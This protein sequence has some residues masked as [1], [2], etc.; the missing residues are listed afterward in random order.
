MIIILIT[1][2]VIIYFFYFKKKNLETFK[3]STNL[4]NFEFSKKDSNKKQGVFLYTNEGKMGSSNK[5]LQ[6]KSSITIAYSLYKK[7]EKGVLLYIPNNY[8]QIS[9]ETKN[10]KIHIFI[11]YLNKT[12][13]YS[14]K[15]YIYRNNQYNLI[16]SLIF[17]ESKHELYV[18]NK[19]MHFYDSL[20]RNN[21]LIK[22]MITDKP[23][24][25]NKGKQLKGILHGLVTHNRII[26]QKE[27]KA[28]Y[29]EFKSTFPIENKKNI[30]V[31][32]DKKK[33]NAPCNFKNE[34]LC[35]VC[36]KTEID[37]ENS[38]I[39]YE[40][41]KCEKMIKN[42]CKSNKDNTCDVISVINKLRK[43]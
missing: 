43:Y 34:D 27:I 29:T 22:Y 23:I 1:F 28:L 17:N 15:R 13:H 36:N 2:M 12:Y 10:E 24:I 31:A 35:N 40:N 39:T 5:L 37:L 4:N 18:N 38:K 6:K 8:C 11:S 26:T 14:L 9:L 19:K 33:L 41:K 30:P 3:I 32:N 16:I 7:D 20:F 42:Y 25:I 21:K